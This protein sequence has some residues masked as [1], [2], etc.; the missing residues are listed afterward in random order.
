MSSPCLSAEQIRAL[1]AGE[2][3][4]LVE[5]EAILH[6]E[7][8][9]QCERIAAELSEE[10][11]T[12]RIAQRRRGPSIAWNPGELEELRMRLVAYGLYQRA[13]AAAA[14]PL[15]PQPSPPPQEDGL[16]PPQAIAERK[17]AS[18]GSTVRSSAAPTALA[19]EEQ[20]LCGRRLGPL[21]VLRVL[22]SG[23]FGVVF[24]AYDHALARRVALK[25]ARPAVLADPAL[26]ARF[27]R[28]AQALARLD[29]PGIVPVYGAEEMEGLCYLVLAFCPG[30]TLQQYLAQRS[31]P[32]APRQAVALLLPLVEAVGHAHQRGILHRDIK[33]GN[34]LLSGDDPHSVD[35]LRPRLTDFGLAKLM[36]DKASDTLAGLVMGTATY[37]APEQAAG[38]RER[39]GPPGDVYALGVVLYELL[40]GRVPIAGGS[41]LET[42][43]RLMVELPLPP[44]VHQPNIDRDL[45]A[46]ALRCLAKSPHDRY[47]SAE[48]L[49]DD[50]RHWL[51][52]RPVR[53]RRHGW[54]RRGWQQVARHR[55]GLVVALLSAA[56][57]GLG[58]G[59]AW[60]RRAHR[61]LQQQSQQTQQEQERTRREADRQALQLARQEYAAVLRAAA[62]SAQVG[63]Y[64]VVARS[65]AD[66]AERTSVAG[67]ADLRGFEWHYLQALTTRPPLRESAS[68]AESYQT[69]L[70]P[71]GREL[72]AAGKDGLLRRYGTATLALVAAWPTGQGELNGVDVSPDGQW[73]ATAGDDGTLCVCEAASGAR[74]LR[75]AAHRVKAFGVRFYDQ[76][77]R[78]ASCGEEPAVRLWD[79]ATGQPLGVLE[80]HAAA[81]RVAMLAVTADGRYLASAG[82]DA[83]VVL[84]DLSEQRAVWTLKGHTRAVSAIAFSPDGRHLVSGSLDQS[85]CVWD[86]PSGQRLAA[87]TLL[88]PVQCVALTAAAAWC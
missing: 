80:G 23:T 11:Q 1:L 15:P 57:L 72:V 81:H 35:A 68:S 19:A 28:E 84:W 5:E 64:A 18:P 78:L 59:V 3:A 32:L 26:R 34:I 25:V 9:P 83:T 22:G 42:L 40:T 52:G 7:S 79:A 71:S 41:T 82:S 31:A 33:P 4:G 88:N 51:A 54:W 77:R 8:C 39:I 87:A 37:M 17:A 49:A 60:M 10:P 30:P 24:E 36:E 44:S 86:V 50:L 70:S 2:L 63:D 75:I 85:V 16:A 56:V 58:G 48:A 21:E 73:L 46:I 53:A 61:Q 65:L 6:L 13:E 67:A 76:G 20:P 27:F 43:R 74:R 62:D 29:H 38:H 69:V 14:E 12:R 45:D 47:P 55:G 66:L